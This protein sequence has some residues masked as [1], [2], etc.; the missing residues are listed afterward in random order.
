MWNVR[1]LRYLNDYSAST[2][3]VFHD[4]SHTCVVKNKF[5]QST[6]KEILK[7]IRCHPTVKPSKL[8]NNEM[9]NVMSSEHFN[10]KEVENIA[11]QFANVKRI[12]N[13]RDGLRKELNPIGENFEAVGQFRKK[14]A[15]KDEF[16]IYSINSRDLNGQPSYVFKSSNGMAKLALMMDRDGDEILSG[17]YAFI[18][19]THTRCRDFKSITLWTYHPVMRKLLRIAIMEVKKEDTENLTKFWELLNEMLFKMA[20]KKFNPTGFVADEHHANWISIHNV[21]G[22]DVLDR[23]VSCEFHYKQSVQRHSKK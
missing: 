9:V 15:E 3:T 17:E 19:A 13:V 10:W 23:V 22:K 11:E 1:L 2:V 21:F 20:G 8:L 6:R 14:C 12:Q 16:L 4:G 7:A 5:T 18:D